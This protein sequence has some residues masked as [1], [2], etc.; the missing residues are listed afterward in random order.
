MRKYITEYIGT[1][2]LML[3]VL[4]AGDPLAIGAILMAMIF[5]GAHISGAHYNPA[6][7]LAVLIRGR[8]KLPEA[9]GYVMVQI[10]GAL[11]AVLLINIMVGDA[12]RTLLDLEG[13]IPEAILA[14]VLGTFALA[15]V[16]LNVATAKGTAA[17]S[18]YGLAIG[19]TI[20]ACAAGLG[21]F[22]GG[23]FN[24]AVAIGASTAN[25]FAWNNIWIYLLGCFGG[26]VLAALVFRISN[27]DDR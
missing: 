25:L 3:I 2:F 4:A 12:P 14:E 18:F 1:F 27:P 21:K 8:I 5:A 10:A 11:T 13:K 23:A 16:V 17:N 9:V 24:P 15:Y 22:S 6:V 26:A 7:T 19:F 20:F